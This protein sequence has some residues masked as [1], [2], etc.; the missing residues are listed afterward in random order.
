MVAGPEVRGGGARDRTW[1]RWRGDCRSL[2]VTT[3]SDIGAFPADDPLCLGVIGTAGHPSAHRY[4]NEVADLVIVVGSS[5][6]IMQR[7]PVMDG[8]GRAGTV[9]VC[10]EVC[11][12]PGHFRSHAHRVGRVGF[13]HYVAVDAAMLP[14]GPGAADG[15]RPTRIPATHRGRTEVDH[16]PNSEGLYFSLRRSR[17]FSEFCLATASSLRRGELRGE[18]RSTTTWYRLTCGRGAYRMGGMGYLVRARLG[19]AS[20][21]PRQSERWFSAVTGPS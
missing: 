6:E 14:V 17:R 19:Q 10:P 11:S 15:L 2:W 16:H 7:A 9:F 13:H 3:L 5:L 8:L 4:V 21:D 1:S 12:V 18:V 20:P